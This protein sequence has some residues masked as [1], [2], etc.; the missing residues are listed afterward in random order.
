MA[1]GSI[2][3]LSAKY[4][5][6]VQRYDSSFVRSQTAVRIRRGAPKLAYRS[7][8]PSGQPAPFQEG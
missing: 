4:A 7:H 6:L 8:P 5:P 1:W 2:P 3:L